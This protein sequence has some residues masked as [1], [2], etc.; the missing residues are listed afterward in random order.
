M[1]INEN[2][3]TV[4][5]TPTETGILTGSVTFNETA[6]CNITINVNAGYTVSPA[7]VTQTEANQRC[8]TNIMNNGVA[9][10]YNNIHNS[11]L[12]LNYVKD[13]SNDVIVARGIDNSAKSET[14][15]N[16]LMIVRSGNSNG[17]IDFMAYTGELPNGTYT[18]KFTY[19]DTNNVNHE[20][21]ITFVMNIP[22]Q[23]YSLTPTEVSDTI[24]IDSS[25]TTT[26]TLTVGSDFDYAEISDDGG[27]YGGTITVSESTMSAGGTFTVDYRGSTTDTDVFTIT[28]TCH[29][30]GGLSDIELTSTFRIT[31]YD[32]FDP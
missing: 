5:I 14:T 26:L 31:V 18:V 15:G 22:V 11:E 25:S 3:A 17:N 6:T 24:D 13:N 27:I 28:V 12:T 4:S 1:S 30:T 8:Y 2:T 21:Y 29:R 23:T 10:D 9:I 16:T 19:K 20:L 7:T 32:P